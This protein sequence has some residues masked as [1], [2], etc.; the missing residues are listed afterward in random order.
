MAAK[1]YTIS[2]E[3]KLQY[4]QTAH[5]AIPSS[6]DIPFIDIAFDPEGTFLV[7]AFATFARLYMYA[8]GSDAEY[9]ENWKL[10][11]VYTIKNTTA[12]ISC[13]HWLSNALLVFGF[14]DGEVVL[15]K[16]TTHVCSHFKI[17]YIQ[18]MANSM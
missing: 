16:T 13:V 6:L 7:V 4:H 11:C 1:E 12:T 15:L 8:E 5:L 9:A 10:R 18:A 17:P 14:D 2:T 3:T